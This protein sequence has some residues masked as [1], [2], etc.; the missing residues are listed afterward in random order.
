[1]VPY[2]SIPCSVLVDHVKYR[3]LQAFLAGQYPPGARIVET[4]VARELGTSQA[5]VREALRDL[6]A[7]GVVET[8]AFRGARVRRPTAAELLEAFVVRA[9]LESLAARLAIPRLGDDDLEALDGLIRDMIAAAER[10]D[11]HA[12]ALADAGFHGRIVELAA[13]ATLLRV[14]RTLEPYSRTYITMATPGADPRAIADH[15]VPVLEAL[16][17][18]DPDVV[19]DVLRRH[20][21]DAAATI[22][23]SL[24]ERRPT[25]AE[26][27]PAPPATTPRPGSSRSRRRPATPAPALR[28]PSAPAGDPNNERTT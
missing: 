8:T 22:T 6:E 2:A 9:Q 10:G 26:R 13:N 1:M 11:V 17:G 25:P 19:T 23:R 15:H 12:E 18:R 24:A 14:W 28:A 20:F 4:R 5:P 3:L 27:P 7:L 21:E 16:R